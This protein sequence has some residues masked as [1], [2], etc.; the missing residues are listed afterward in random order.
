MSLIICPECKK[1]ISDNASSCPNC[2]MLMRSNSIVYGCFDGCIG[3][4][5]FILGAI[6]FIIILIFSIIFF[7]AL[8]S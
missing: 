4:V 8:Y 3:M 5:M 6:A 2:G 1:E 7:L